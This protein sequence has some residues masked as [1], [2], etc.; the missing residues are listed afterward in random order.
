MRNHIIPLTEASGELNLH[1]TFL[2]RYIANPINQ[3]PQPGVLIFSLLPLDSVCLLAVSHGNSQPP[4]LQQNIH[5]CV[6]Y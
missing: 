5:G 6:F 4:E 1:L 3:L 2:R